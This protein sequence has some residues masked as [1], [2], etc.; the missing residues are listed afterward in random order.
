MLTTP[1]TF[2]D[3]RQHQR[4]EGNPLRLRSRR[5]LGMDRL[6]YAGN[7]LARSHAA[8][9]GRRHREALRLQR[10]NRSNQCVMPVG[11][12]LRHRLAVGNALR[13]IRVGNQKTAA[14]GD[15]QGANLERVIVKVSHGLRSTDQG[16]ELLHI[17]WLDRA[18]RGHRQ[19]LAVGADEH[20]MAGAFLP[21][22]DPVLPRHR[23]QLLDAPIQRLAAHG[24]EQFRG[25]VH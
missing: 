4:I 5:E 2:R 21:P 24:F 19:S 7:E 17:D 9:V 23:L 16:H 14:L 3:K 18:M 1:K 22:V 11:D 20:A 15:R 10:A 8:A 13:E 25:G 12:G 6:G